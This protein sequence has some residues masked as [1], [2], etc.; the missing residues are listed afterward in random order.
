MNAVSEHVIGSSFD[1]ESGDVCWVDEETGRVRFSPK[2]N[3]P[4]PKVRQGN[5]LRECYMKL[6]DL[7][8]DLESWAERSGLVMRMSPARQRKIEFIFE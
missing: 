3:Q 6:E 4:R 5:I 2:S 7:K 8:A 1:L